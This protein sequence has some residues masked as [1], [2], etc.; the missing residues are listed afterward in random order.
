M[1]DANDVA[2][3]QLYL[4][5]QRPQEALKLLGAALARNPDDSAALRTLALAHLQADRGRAGGDQAVRAATQAVTLSPHDSFAWRILALG[6]SRLGKHSDARK[7]AR[8]A[9]SLAPEFWGSGRSTR[10]CSSVG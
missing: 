10:G 1:T 6:Y 4:D 8:T 9:Q 7:V 5:L 3:A 2:Q